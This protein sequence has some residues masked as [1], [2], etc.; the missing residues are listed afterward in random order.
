[1]AQIGRAPE[2]TMTFATVLVHV[3]LEH[4][5]DAHLRLAGDV[6]EQFGAR[7]IGAAAA[8]PQPQYYADNPFAANL[9]A[10][11]RARVKE[12]MATAETMFRTEL[13]NRVKDIEWRGAFAPPANFL[14]REAR[15]A[16]LVVAGARRN[17]GILD[18][19]YQL[20][21]GD[22]VMHLGRP[23]LVVPPDAERFNANRIVVGWKDT[24]E[25]RRAVADA[26]PFLRKAN[27]VNVVEI[28]DD[29]NDRS[30]AAKRLADVVAWL[31]RHGIHAVPTVPARTGKSGETLETFASN[32]RADLIVAGAFGHTRLREWVLGGM[33]R[34]LLTQSN[35]CVMLSH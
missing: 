4:P 2:L 34:D 13:G 18:P 7:V 32:A 22:L 3:D 5:S 12:Q 1:M 26:L 8:D 29:E 14:A 16:D 11:L 19:L 27:E 15:A 25:A 21:L 33:T 20:D 10:Q 31:G 30:A 17:G 35:R 28:V 6:A 9:V 24:R 23:L